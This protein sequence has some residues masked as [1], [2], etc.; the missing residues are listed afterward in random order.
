MKILILA[1]N[2]RAR[3][4]VSQYTRNLKEILAR[5]YK[6]NNVFVIS[7]CSPQDPSLN[8]F[9]KLIF[10]VKILIFALLKKP[11]LIIAAHEGLSPIAWI[12]R[13]VFKINYW[14]LVY[15]V[16]VWVPLAP[17]KKKALS[18]SQLIISI[19]EFTRKT[20]IEKSKIDPLK[21]YILNNFI[22]C[23]K[24]KPESKS[25]SLLDKY[26]L[27]EKLIILTLGNLNSSERYK[28]HDLTIKA[29][30]ELQHDFPNLIYL[31]I[32]E[33]D[34]RGRLENI[35]SDYGM[36]GKVIFT[37]EVEEKMLSSFYN[38]AD[39]FCMPSWGEGF[40]FV[41]LEAAACEKPVIAGRA[42]G[43]LEAISENKSGFLVDPGNISDLK[44]A[45]RKL[46]V[47]EELRKNMGR[48]GRK[49]VIEN[50]SLEVAENKL[51]KIFEDTGISVK[52]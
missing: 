17:L 43:A 8:F 13:I 37:G 11:N 41:Y 44:A 1:T 40:G 38:L 52:N 51:R 35:V 5:I 25:G 9:K 36:T 24:F 30:A 32:G 10:S 45:L 27:R 19:S 6:E 23:N 34:D 12:C 47:S 21:I 50:F 28:G 39:V 14:V 7:L 48:E 15:G 4:G 42:G 26:K 33:G 3:G 29:V 2:F 22:D 49:M 16:E 20:L 18:S 46:L 31:I